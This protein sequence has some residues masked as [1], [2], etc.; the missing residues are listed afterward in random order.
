MTFVIDEIIEYIEKARNL[1]P[2]IAD[3]LL[4]KDS[5][6]AFGL[7]YTVYYM[8]GNGG[9]D[10]DFNVNGRTCE[11]MVFYKDT[12]RGF[13]RVWANDDDTIS[14]YCYAN[15][16]FMPLEV[17]GTLETVKIPEGSAEKFAYKLQKAA[18]DKGLFDNPVSCFYESM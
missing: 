5:E 14:G 18:D 15:G 13:L 11:F 12:K 3:G 6:D 10:F 2:E 9:T 1:H 4:L 16:E 8:N 17:G 7:P